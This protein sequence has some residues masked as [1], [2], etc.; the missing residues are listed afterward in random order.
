MRLLVR[1]P[2]LYSAVGVHVY[3]YALACRRTMPIQCGWG[4]RSVRSC[5]FIREPCLYSAVGVHVVHVLV[6]K[7]CLYSAQFVFFLWLMS[8]P[9]EALQLILNCPKLLRT[10]L[11]HRVSVCRLLTSSSVGFDGQQFLR[12]VRGRGGLPD[13]GCWRLVLPPGELEHA[14]CTHRMDQVM[15]VSTVCRKGLLQD[16]V[17]YTP[18]PSPRTSSSPSACYLRVFGHVVGI[19]LM[20]AIHDRSGG[21]TINININT[22]TADRG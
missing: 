13:D 15:I 18:P 14:A 19:W 7:P 6:R 1:E 5:L 10:C 22:R 2:S 4:A 12:H 3:R 20:A 11:T 8:C 16:R 17:M 21:A 9:I